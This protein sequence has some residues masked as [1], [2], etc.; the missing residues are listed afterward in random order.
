MN[1]RPGPGIVEWLRQAGAKDVK[2]EIHSFKMG[3]A[4]DDEE[5]RI[6]TT[7]NMNSII[8]NFA[9]VGSST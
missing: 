9:M 1:H 4:A 7:E 3:A 2:E 6:E 5:M 8:A